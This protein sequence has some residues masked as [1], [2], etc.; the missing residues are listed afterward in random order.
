MQAW[1]SEYRAFKD[2]LSILDK[3]RLE[4][5][6]ERR[7]F[8]KLELKVVHSKQASD[9]VDPELAGKMEAKNGDVA[10][11]T[12]LSLCLCIDSWNDCTA[13]VS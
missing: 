5:D 2:K 12:R 11:T 6:A 10:G 9:S 7:A 1:I 8:H 3:H 13:S 4:F